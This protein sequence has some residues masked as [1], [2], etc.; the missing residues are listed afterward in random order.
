MCLLLAKM[1]NILYP[2]TMMY[3]RRLLS[4]VLA[5]VA[6]GLAAGFGPLVQAAGAE[7]GPPTN[8]WESAIAAFE[9]M[10]QTNPPPRQAILFVGSSSIRLWPNLEQ[11]FPRHTVFARG[12]GGSELSEAVTFADRI[13]LPYRPKVI[14]LY[15]GDND[16][17]NGKSPERVLADFKAFTQKV[18]AA[19]PQTRL[20]FIAIKPCPARKAF[21]SQVKTANLLIKGYI[22]QNPNLFFVDVFT[23]MLDPDSGLRPELL[24]RDGLHLNERGYALW[25]SII[26]PLLDKYD[27]PVGPTP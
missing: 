17:A 6:I 24:G 18:H 10:D 12:F 3:K 5:A 2:L 26:R 11:D 8:R 14:M 23:P 20:G 16:I 4:L 9:A 7:P 25:A 22:G 21:L 27:P 19:L 15:A 13:V 1:D